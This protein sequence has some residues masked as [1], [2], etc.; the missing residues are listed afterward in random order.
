MKA[1]IVAGMLVLIVTPFLLFA[2][3]MT[4]FPL[5]PELPDV[6]ETSEV[7]EPTTVSVLVTKEKI[8]WGTQLKKP[9]LLF[10]QMQFIKGNEPPDAITSFEQLKDYS[11]MKKTLQAG[12]P[13]TR[14][15]LMLD[16]DVALK[17]RLSNLPKGTRAVKVPVVNFFERGEQVFPNS[18]VDVVSLICSQE[19]DPANPVLVQHLLVLDVTH[20]GLED[21]PIL[22]TL[23]AT[24]EEAEILD[25]AAL[26][27]RL[28]VR[29]N[30]K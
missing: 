22:V 8:L 23:Q 4:T 7:L 19:D 9:E 28:A 20:S 27:A 6:E 17:I 24:N 13:V 25:S 12:S 30:P 5:N 3:R 10:T 15:D 14:N 2:L 21:R 26:C 29:L 11:H 18:R 1:R 16:W